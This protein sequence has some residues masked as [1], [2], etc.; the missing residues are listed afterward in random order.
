MTK[1]MLPQKAMGNLATYMG[2]DS[3]K[4]ISDVKTNRVGETYYI[5][6]VLTREI[7]QDALKELV[8]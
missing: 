2:V 3:P 6:V 8:K 7:S 5:S 4:H 1:E